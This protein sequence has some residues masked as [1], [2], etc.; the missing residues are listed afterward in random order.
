MRVKCCEYLRLLVPL[1]LQVHPGT[2]AFM[3]LT[4][5]GSAT[6]VIRMVPFVR[7]AAACVF[8]FAPLAFPAHQ[9]CAEAGHCQ[10]IFLK[11]LLPG[12]NPKI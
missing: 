4:D 12:K 5:R 1:F 11:E 9:C 10:T 3:P 8:A 6:V 2:V 7:S